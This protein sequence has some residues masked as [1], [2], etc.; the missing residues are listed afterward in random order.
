MGGNLITDTSLTLSPHNQTGQEDVKIETE[1]DKSYSIFKKVINA[2][3]H[4]PKIKNKSKHIL[5]QNNVGVN[6]KR[7]KKSLNQTS[8]TTRS[9]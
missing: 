9:L 1:Y 3:C 6:L 7:L 8:S 5:K 4:P 2:N